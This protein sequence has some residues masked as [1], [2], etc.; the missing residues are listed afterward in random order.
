MEDKGVLFLS[1]TV[2]YETCNVI[3]K[4]IIQANYEPKTD[5]IQL[6]ISSSGGVVDA[7]FSLIDVMEWSRIP[8]Y[9]TALGEACSMAFLILMAGET[10]HRACS[11]RT[12]LMS[13]RFWGVSSGNYSDLVAYRQR[14]DKTH[15]QMV[16]HY[17]RHTKLRNK[18]EVEKILLKDID[19]WITPE[20]ALKYGVIDR[21]V[22]PK[23]GFVK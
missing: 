22:V 5:F 17:I 15:E 19:N 11:K 20:D 10:G 9:T 12:T 2:D 18:K 7:G 6:L 8:V 23:E 21:L 1:G 14:E 13:H 16:E 3:S 4:H